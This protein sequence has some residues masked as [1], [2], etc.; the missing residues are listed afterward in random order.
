MDARNVASTNNDK[1]NAAFNAG[2]A[3][4]LAALYT[5][6]SDGITTYS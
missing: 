6:E 4:S 2:E 5:A 1:W 3:T